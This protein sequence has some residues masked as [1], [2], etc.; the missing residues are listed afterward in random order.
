[1]RFK[2]HV[3]SLAL[4]T[5]MLA[6]IVPATAQQTTLDTLRIS[7]AGLTPFEEK[8]IGRSYT[9][10]DGDKIQLSGTP[11]VADI[12]RQ[13][14]GFAVTSGGSQSG[15]TDV[16]VRGGEA[17]HVLVLIDGVPISE[18]W[19]GG[20]DFGRLQVANVE[21]I[22][23]LR[24]PQSAFWGANAM[25]GV[26]NI[27]TKSAKDDGFHGSVAGEMGSDG[28]KMTSGSLAYGQDNFKA[29][30]GITLRHTDGFNISSLGSELDSARHVDANARFSANITPQ[31][32]LDGTVRYGRMSGDSDDQDFAT[33]TV[34]DTNDTFR[35]NELFGSLGLGWVSEDGVW[36]QNARVSGGTIERGSTNVWGETVYAGDLYKA[37]Y[38]IGRNFETPGILDSTHT[39]TLGYDLVYETFQHLVPSVMDRQTRTAHSVVGEYRGTFYDQF[40]LTAALRHD[41]NA[42]FADATTYSVSG[43]WQIPN[44]GTKLHASVGTGST[45]PTMWE[46][47]GYSPGSFT[48]NPNLTPETSVGWDI[49]IEQTLLD[50]MVV[51]DATYFNQTLENKIRDVF[52]PITTAINVPGTS[53]RQGVELSATV[54]VFDGLAAGVTYTYLDARDPSGALEV[55]RPQHSGSLNL[56]YT[57]P[58]IP[59]T[60]HGEVLL[61]GETKDALGAKTFTLPAYAVVNAGLNYQVSDQVEVYGRV[62]NLFDTK[63]QEVYGYNTQGRTFYAGARA[64]F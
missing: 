58:E 7:A 47:F 13:V 3:S 11:Y 44:T 38:Q 33:G 54:N 31:L 60:L 49:G 20:V 45:N 36:F 62:H 6:A 41:F 8:E 18:T 29:S 27:V 2:P 37:S 61:R 42:N 40:Y 26:I 22:E 9:V 39:V 59:L 32:T 63:Y 57:L 17:N 52:F 55:R 16:R 4:L 19:T 48:P 64:K 28:T 14:P 5:A 24:G 46:Q 34:L 1:M 23:V 56:A 10:I 53:P 43:A 30:G 15:L 50:G 12:L 51:L 25:S 35:A 21:R